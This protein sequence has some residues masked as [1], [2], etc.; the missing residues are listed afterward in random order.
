[1]CLDQKKIKE[2][3]KGCTNLKLQ[4]SAY[5]ACFLSCSPLTLTN[6]SNTT[7]IVSEAQVVVAAQVVIV[8]QIAIVTQVAITVQAMIAAHIL[9]IS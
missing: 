6:A 8:A 3:E 2:L 1:M 5:R 9:C 7:Q 4:T